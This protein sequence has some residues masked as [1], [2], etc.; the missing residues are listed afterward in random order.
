MGTAVKWGPCGAAVR[1]AVQPKLCPEPSGQ[2]GRNAI[3]DQPRQMEKR[4]EV[5][6]L[7]RE[8]IDVCCRL[9]GAATWRTRQ[10]VDITDMGAG[11]DELRAAQRILDDRFA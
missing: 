10:Q 11:S 1:V 4:S 5:A 8:R 2:V 6:A 7:E 9:H 3:R